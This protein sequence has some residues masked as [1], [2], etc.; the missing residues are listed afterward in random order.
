L[1]GRGVIRVDA[2]SNANPPAASDYLLGKASGLRAYLRVLVADG[3][4]AEDVLQE[5]FLRFIRS[6][7][8]A[9]TEDANRWLFRV[10]RN[11]GLKVIRSRRRRRAREATYQG[12]NQTPSR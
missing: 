1:A 7:P 6:G 3:H 9:G 11:L 12:K 5:L 2:M 10:A 8:P 4:E